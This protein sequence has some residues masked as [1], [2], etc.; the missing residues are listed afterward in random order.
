MGSNGRKM[1]GGEKVHL[2]KIEREAHIHE[3][4]ARDNLVFR[5]LVVG[6]EA[7]AA[8]AGEI[9]AGGA[10]R[11]DKEL[12]HVLEALELVGAAPAE[13]VDVEA[14]GLGKQQVGLVAN[15]GEALEEADAD[16]AVG[17]DLGQRKGGGLDVKAALDDLEVGGD[18]AQVLVGLLVSEVAEAE[19]LADLAGGEEFFELGVSTELGAVEFGKANLW[20]NVQSAVWDVQVADDEDEE[21]HLVRVGPEG[22]GTG[23]RARRVWAR[24]ARLLDSSAVLLVLRGDRGQAASGQGRVCGRVRTWAWSWRRGGDGEAPIRHTASGDGTG[25]LWRRPQT[26]AIVLE[27]VGADRSARRG[28]G[29]ARNAVRGEG[30]RSDFNEAAG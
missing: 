18:G 28:V 30:G 2:K 14:V 7:G 26:M 4:E 11:V 10:A 29:R 12:V 27:P 20:R 5:L 24:Q 19:R 1:E 25:C 21:R 17:D 8:P 15:E 3:A 23:R 13:D 6:A 22:R 16:G 9:G